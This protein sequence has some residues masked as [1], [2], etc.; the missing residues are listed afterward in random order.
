M[1]YTITQSKDPE[2]YE[3]WSE[4]TSVK[5]KNVPMLCA[6]IH[7]DCL[8]PDIVSAVKEAEEVEV[9]FSFGKS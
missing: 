2:M 3:L 1:V 5:G 9:H 4:Y 8:D 7:T 6:V